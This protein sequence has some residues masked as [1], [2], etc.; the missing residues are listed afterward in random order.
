[1]NFVLCIL[2]DNDDVVIRQKEKK[3]GLLKENVIKNIY[4]YRMNRK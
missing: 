2:C 3:F 1:M 4:R